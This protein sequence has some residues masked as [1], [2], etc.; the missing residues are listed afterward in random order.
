M[1]IEV[2][3]QRYREALQ[4]WYSGAAEATRLLSSTDDR[5]TFCY[6]YVTWSFSDRSTKW[7]TFEHIEAYETAREGAD[8]GQV[9]V[10]PVRSDVPE[11]TTDAGP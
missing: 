8:Y 5:Y 10:L 9:D 7:D 2:L 6:R 1:G 11:R 4:Y 3:I